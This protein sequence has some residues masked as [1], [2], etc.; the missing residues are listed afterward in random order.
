MSESQVAQVMGRNLYRDSLSG[1]TKFADHGE[2]LPSGKWESWFEDN[3]KGLDPLMV[4]V[5][6]GIVHG[7]HL[8]DFPEV[9]QTLN[10]GGSKLYPHD[11]EYRIVSVRTREWEGGE[12]FHIEVERVGE[13]DDTKLIHLMSPMNI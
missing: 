7:I 8:P 1:G 3:L 6:K 13:I 11:G 4:L 12:T 5:G 9:G 2:E 10:L